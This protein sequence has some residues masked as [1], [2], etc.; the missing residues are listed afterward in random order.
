[1]RAKLKK[2]AST[3]RGVLP[4]AVIATIE[5]KHSPAPTLPPAPVQQ[6]LLFPA[7]APG[8]SVG[9]GTQGQPIVLNP[10]YGGLPGAPVILA[11]PSA[12]V[13]PQVTY[14]LLQSAPGQPGGY[15]IVQQPGPAY[16]QPPSTV[17]QYVTAA[18][19][20][21]PNGLPSSSTP[22]LPVQPAYMQGGPHL[23]AGPGSLASSLLGLG[24][25]RGAGH[26]AGSHP[27]LAGM[28]GSGGGAP[29]SADQLL[30]QQ[31]LKVSPKGL[32]LVRACNCVVYIRCQGSTASARVQ[33][34]GKLLRCAGLKPCLCLHLCKGTAS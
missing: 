29:P 9:Y 5:A 34:L 18:G 19:Q 11:P 13:Q 24:L 14:T 12:Q 4:A 6:T 2:T 7:Q 10:A 15:A 1:V 16:G 21:A 8:P 23:Q 31:A 27:N 32:C 3:W 30:T 20:P 25:Q 22:P 26:Q 33:G 17:I 28:N